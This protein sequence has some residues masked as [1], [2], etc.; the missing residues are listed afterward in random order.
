MKHSSFLAASVAAA[1]SLC[2]CQPEVV[3]MLVDMRKAPSLGIDIN[4]KTVSVVYLDD[5]SGKDTVFNASVAK[6]FARAL[7]EEYFGGGEAVAIYRM[8]KDMAGDYASRDSLVRMALDSGDDVVFAFDSP[9]YK[10][11]VLESRRALAQNGDSLDFVKAKLPFRLSLYAYDTLDPSDTVRTF[12][13][14]SSVTKEMVCPRTD[15]EEDI[16]WKLSGELGEAGEKTGTRS[17]AGFLSGW[18]S[19]QV[20]FYNMPFP[21]DWVMATSCAFQCKWTKAIDLWTGMLDTGNLLRRAALEYN[22][23]NAM[24]LMG[25]RELAAR[26]CDL[27]LKHANLP[28]ALELRKRLR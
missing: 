10:G 7:E 17:A 15:T 23:A 22:I 1:L 2:S 25:D 12:S 6:G 26:W 4:G 5:L 13:G 27:S 8:E 28:L 24:F 9:V 19:K 16:L 21:E 3:S 14:S 20:S 18:T 11:I